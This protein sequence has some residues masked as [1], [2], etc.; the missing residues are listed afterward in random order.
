M[1]PTERAADFLATAHKY[2]FKVIRATAHVI[3]IEARFAPHDAAALTD[4]DMTYNI[5]WDRLDYT[6]ERNHWGTDCGGIG[7]VAALRSGVFTHNASGMKTA[8][9]KAVQKLWRERTGRPAAPRT[10]ATA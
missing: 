6:R 5:V 2:G 9:A 10:S 7:A 4:C 8:D 1:T 3:T